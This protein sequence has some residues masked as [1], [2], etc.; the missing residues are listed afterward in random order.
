MSSIQDRIKED[1]ALSAIHEYCEHPSE[2]TE[3][4]PSV[5][6]GSDYHEDAF[7]INCHCLRCGKTWTEEQ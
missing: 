3:R 4:L 7:W 2:H 5:S 1:L 6:T